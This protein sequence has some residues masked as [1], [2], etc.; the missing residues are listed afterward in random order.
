MKKLLII[1][2][3]FLSSCAGTQIQSSKSENFKISRFTKVIVIAAC[4][5]LEEKRET[6]NI[7]SKEL[8]H[9][10]LKGISYLS[11]FLPEKNY[12]EKETE[13]LLNK[14]SVNGSIVIIKTAEFKSERYISPQFFDMAVMSGS[15]DM[16]FGTPLEGYYLTEGITKYNISLLDRKN[17]KIWCAKATTKGSNK[18]MIYKSLAKTTIK[19]LRKD[20][21]IH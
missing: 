10:A 5:D 1:S 12:T 2:L 9:T 6:E 21:I 11:I 14:N 7:F 4:A 17:N 13:D 3:F 8:N 20:G 15:R 18:R 19:K 16:F